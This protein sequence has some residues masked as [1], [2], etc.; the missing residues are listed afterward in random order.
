MI[1]NNNEL[2]NKEVYCLCCNDKG[3][4]AVQ[5]AD[6]TYELEECLCVLE[7]WLALHGLG[8]EDGQDSR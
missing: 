3:H 5:L 8:E 7:K 2:E 1:N 6:G 4:V